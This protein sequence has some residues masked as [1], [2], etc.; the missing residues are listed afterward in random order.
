M[1][2][3]LLKSLRMR[4]TMILLFSFLFI[5][6]LAQTPIT[7]D[8]F[9]ADSILNELTI[10]HNSS[11]AAKI[12]F[13][14]FQLTTSSGTVKYKNTMLSEIALM[15]LTF[16]INVTENVTVV[17][18][19]SVAILRGKLHQKGT[20]KGKSFDHFLLVTDT[21]VLTEN[22]WKLLAGHATLLPKA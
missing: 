15:E 19:G 10:T 6:S 3:L 11:E 22:K 13:D 14:S 12:Y 18:E 1:A 17:I 5:G 2:T 9:K 16:D 21:W 4:C 8:V 7:K 20:Y